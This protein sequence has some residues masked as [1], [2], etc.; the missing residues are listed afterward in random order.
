MA[1]AIQDPVIIIGMYVIF[2]LL[3]FADD[4]VAIWVKQATSSENP[5]GYLS[6]ITFNISII[7]LGC[8][9][10]FK[11]SIAVIP[12]IG[13]LVLYTGI[14]MMELFRLAIGLSLIVDGKL[15]DVMDRMIAESV[16]DM[17]KDGKLP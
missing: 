3:L 14:T 11:E 15:E 8:M 9:A 6:I 2:G 10:L 13:L 7:W 5:F 1:E 12:V 17:K 4:V 16:D